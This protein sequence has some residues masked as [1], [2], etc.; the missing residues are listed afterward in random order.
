MTLSDKKISF[1]VKQLLI[2]AGI[3]LILII[4]GALF[5]SQYQ[6]GIYKK[7]S[8][9]QKGVA[10]NSPQRIE[11]QGQ[12][13]MLDGDFCRQ[14]TGKRIPITINLINAANPGA[15]PSGNTM[16]AID[17]ENSPDYIDTQADPATAP[18]NRNCWMKESLYRP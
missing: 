2:Y 9:G 18:A 5:L 8:F 17:R 1:S 10:E 11:Y 15:D 6:L 13:Y 3:P 4:A 16:Y 12:R 7:G 14:S